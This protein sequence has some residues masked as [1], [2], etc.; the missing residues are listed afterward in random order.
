MNKYK[1]LKQLYVD[2]TFQIGDKGFM[3][4]NDGSGRS[5]FCN[6]ETA[7]PVH[8]PDEDMKFS[9]KIL[10]LTTDKFVWELYHES[11]KRMKEF[12]ANQDHS[13]AKLAVIETKLEELQ[14]LFN[15]NV[16]KV[17][18][19]SCPICFEEMSFNTKIA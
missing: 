14:N 10:K 12:K 16:N 8:K 13:N 11:N 15:N 4:P 7:F 18:K 17:K 3:E 1:S 2:Y 9:C 6:H 19:P 5:K